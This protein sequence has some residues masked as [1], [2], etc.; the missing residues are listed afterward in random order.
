MPRKPTRR[1]ISR[2]PA[3]AAGTVLAGHFMPRRNFFARG[4]KTGQD[5]MRTGKAA[6]IRAMTLDTIISSPPA[7]YITTRGTTCHC[8]FADVSA[9]S[10]PLH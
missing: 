2:R 5:N 4:K 10:P 3:G 6:A 7:G 8:R 9:R 1:D